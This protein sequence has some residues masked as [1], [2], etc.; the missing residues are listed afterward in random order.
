MKTT[1]KPGKQK[2]GMHRHK[3]SLDERL[4]R[5]AQTSEVNER[6]IQNIIR[7]SEVERKAHECEIQGIIRKSEYEIQEII[8]KSEVERKAHERE[9]RE[10]QKSMNESNKENNGYRR[11][12]SRA[13]EDTF[14]AALP[15]V[16]KAV[17]Q[18]VIQPEDIR[19]R[20]RK[21]NHTCEFDFVA[22]NG[23]LVLVGEVKTRLTRVDVGYFCDL[24][25][26]EFRKLFPEF[27]DLPVYGVVAGLG[28]DKDAADAAFE[29]GFYILRMEG[30]DLHP[31][32]KEGYYAR[33]Y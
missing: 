9:M 25:S 31:N 11:N 30:S 24:L 8:R 15:R 26:R 19:M 21:S 27:K 12:L 17:H 5:L 13:L 6:Q 18:I 16:M 29:R 22:H 4:E 28:I 14:A 3:L 1:T 23:K 20:V 2:E 33:E 7:K 10:M 32:T